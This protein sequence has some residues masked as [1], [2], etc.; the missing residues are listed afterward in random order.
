MQECK[1]RIDRGQRITRFY[2]R[3]QDT[4]GGLVELVAEPTPHGGQIRL[5]HETFREFISRPPFQALLIGGSSHLRAQ[6]GYTELTKCHFSVLQFSEQLSFGSL[7]KKSTFSLIRDLL[8]YSHLS[9]STTGLSQH[10]LFHSVSK[11]LFISIN[12]QLSRSGIHAVLDTPKPNLAAPSPMGFASR[13]CL[14]LYMRRVLKRQMDRRSNDICIAI[15]AVVDEVIEE[16]NPLF[17]RDPIPMLEF[18]LRKADGRYGKSKYLAFG[19]LIWGNLMLLRITAQMYRRFWTPQMLEAAA[20]FLRDEQDP[21]VRFPGAWVFAVRSPLCHQLHISNSPMT[22]LLLRLNADANGRD[23][24]D[25]TPLDAMIRS[26][27]LSFIGLSS[28]LQEIKDHHFRALAGSINALVRSGGLITR[29]GLQDLPVC[30][31][32]YRAIGLSDGNLE[33]LPQKS[34]ERH[35][36]SSWDIRVVPFT[37]ACTNAARKMSRQFPVA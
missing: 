33:I 36:L 12:E 17:L 5:M 8:T 27:A 21:N 22:D 25:R 24:K 7:P 4:C 6:N 19:R 14:L 16:G 28:N 29:S 26:V 35:Y 2:R 32:A 23:S 18:L 34:L 37:R 9:E 30:L 15:E 10:D 31:R 11:E 1:I 13:S 3:L 20:V